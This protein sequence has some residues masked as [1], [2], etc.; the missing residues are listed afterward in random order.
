MKRK[1][2]KRLLALLLG[3]S[4]V[5][6]SAPMQTRA[7]E[8]Q[9]ITIEKVSAM[10]HS[11]HGAELI[12]DGS[13]ETYWQSIPSNGEGDA[14]KINYSHNRYIDITLDGM[15]DLSQVKIFNKADNSYN[16]YYVYASVDGVNYDKIISKTSNSIATEEG[17]TYSVSAKASHLRLNMAYNSNTYV[18]NLAEIELYGVRVGERNDDTSGIQ[19]ENWQGSSWQK[20]WDRFESDEEYAK[21]KILKEM[22]NLVGRVIG[23]EWQDSFIFEIRKSLQDEKDIFEVKDGQE[24]K[25]V[26]AGNNGLALASGFNYYLKN[27]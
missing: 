12:K 22:E 5:L 4:M 10:S 15:Y 14:Y 11:S 21:A 23:E 6:P 27:Y 17:D 7:A 20:E 3:I 24:G 8:A 16:N 1:G 26:I 13:R 25:I 2:F 9:K 18:T 19:V